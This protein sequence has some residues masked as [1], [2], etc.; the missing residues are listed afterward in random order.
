[1]N[2]ELRLEVIVRFVDID[3]FFNLSC[4]NN[5]C[6]FFYALLAIFA[7]GIKLHI[8]LAVSVVEFCAWSP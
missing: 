4:H 7:T 2:N 6:K 3:G 1:M 5:G 8:R